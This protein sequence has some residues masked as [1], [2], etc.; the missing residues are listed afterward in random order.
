MKKIILLVAIALVSLVSNA[1]NFQKYESMKDVDAMV[2]TS[3][4][5]KLLAKVDLNSTDPQA[6]QYINLIEHLKEIKM[7]T[8]NK[9]TIRSQMATDV[10]S[11]L[12]KGSLEQLMR[13]NEDG[14]NIK[15]YSKPGRNENFV[16]ELF[17]FME[18]EKDGKP[19]SV[20]LSITGDID[21][22]QLSKLA[23]DL[24]VPGAEELK[25]VNK[26]S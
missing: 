17:M 19:I 22:T 20:I 12:S 23:T 26:K 1:Q 16:S 21:L 24:K 15:F 25:K 7:Y 10:S 18:G 14:K 5:F 13:V 2:M 9:Q 4:M 3:K 11:Y 8:T 6:Q